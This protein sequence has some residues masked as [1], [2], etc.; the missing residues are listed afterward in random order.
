M[1]A[2]VEDPRSCVEIV[3]TGPN[4]A[5]L[6]DLA[7]ELIDRRLAACMQISPGVRAV[8][9]W[10]GAVEDETQARARL[11]TRACLVPTVTEAVR[12]RHPDEVPCLLAL[13]IVGGDEQYLDWIADETS[14]RP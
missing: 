6:A 11:H 7:Q 4:E 14:P 1:S 3:L 10:E 5:F 9:R 13:P 8:Y 2:V 12:E